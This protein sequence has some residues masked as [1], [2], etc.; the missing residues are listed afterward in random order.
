MKK[1]DWLVDNELHPGAHFP[2]CIFTKGASSRSEEKRL[3]RLQRKR[4]RW[5]TWDARNLG[6]RSRGRSADS[7]RVEGDAWADS[8]RVPGNGAWAVS[9]RDPGWDAR[10]ALDQSQ[11][12]GGAY[13]VPL[14]VPPFSWRSAP[15]WQWSH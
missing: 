4:N 3:E 10:V 14:H 1:E 8:K 11:C 15:G 9:E 6:A 12:P 2:L 5:S 7:K 13:T